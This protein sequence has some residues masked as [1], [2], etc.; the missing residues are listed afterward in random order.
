MYELFLDRNPS[1]ILTSEDF[2]ALVTRSVS[3]GLYVEFKSELPDTKK[4]AKTIAAFANSQGGWLLIG[5]VERAGGVAGACPGIQVKEGF[6][7]TEFIRNICRDIIAPFPDHTVRTATTS[8]HQLLIAI[9]IP[10]S[11]DTP[12]ICSD[13]TVPI[14]MAASTKAIDPSNYYELNRL[15]DRSVEFRKDYIEFA[16]D[17]RRSNVGFAYG[18]ALS[19]Y[20][21]PVMDSELVFE[22]GDLISAAGL[23]KVKE[24]VNT[25][26]PI[27]IWEGVRAMSTQG[28]DAED[29]FPSGTSQLP[30][31]AIYYHSGSLFLEQG[32]RG[33][34]FAEVDG[35]GRL[36]AHI[37]LHT[38]RV[39][40]E[41]FKGLGPDVRKILQRASKDGYGDFF[42]AVNAWHVTAH[43][44]SMY[45]SLLKN[46]SSAGYR[47]SMELTDIRG[48]VTHVD[49][50]DWVTHVN[51][52]GYARFHAD[53]RAMPGSR[54]T[55]YLV[56]RN[57]QDLRSVS[58]WMTSLLLGVPNDVL[59]SGWDEYI[60]KRSAASAAPK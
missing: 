60:F 30:L 1:D 23:K 58:V 32:R 3:E 17:D 24:Q 18:P 38:F 15:V 11:V 39:A 43:I 42:D 34:I 41:N 31:D 47:I 13:G 33:G 53:K 40:T 48:L 19:I 25:P 35:R 49:S 28:S 36:R 52:C 8:N 2:E 55:P 6:D 4:L 59:W 7:A 14:R 37:P 21:W 27:A 22:I 12:H 16:V 50:V 54:K 9:S 44:I 57:G 26:I 56:A 51:E 29:V 5:V 45:I 20:I 46:D 10:K